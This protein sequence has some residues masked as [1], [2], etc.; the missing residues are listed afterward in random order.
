MRKGSD[1]KV[2]LDFYFE[3]GTYEQLTIQQGQDEEKKILMGE[4]YTVFSQMLDLIIP[5]SDWIKKILPAFNYAEYI[6]VEIPKS[7]NKIFTE[8]WTYLEKAESAYFRWD[9]QGV[10]SNC[11]EVGC[12]LEKALKEKIGTGKVDYEQR[13]G[14]FYKGFNQWASMDLHR[15]DIEV[16]AKKADSEHLIL[17]TKSLIKF[18]EELIKEYK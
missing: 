6:L 11:R 14:R 8:A 13:W 17:V 3:V 2:R 18:A 5:Q 9:S 1:L 15:S 7:G 16:E 12:I 10:F 4:T